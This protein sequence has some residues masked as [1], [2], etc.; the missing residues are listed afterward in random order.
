LAVLMVVVG[1]SVAVAPAAQAGTDT[2]GSSSSRLW[3]WG[4]NER[5]KLGDG[6]TTRRTTPGRVQLS[7]VVA[8]AAGG[9][10]GYALRTDGTLMA[11]GQNA[12]G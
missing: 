2:S 11:W 1:L 6:T 4:S 7:G 5:G 9:I 3:S 12:F 10:S 8:V